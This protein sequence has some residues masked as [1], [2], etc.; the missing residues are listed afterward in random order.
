M[1]TFLLLASLAFAAPDVIN[2]PMQATRATV[3]ASATITNAGPVMVAT[4][5][6][7]RLGLV[8]Y[9]NSANTVYIKFG[10]PG[11]AGTDMT[12][13]IATFQSYQMP[14]PIF[15]GALFGIRN[16]GTGVVVATEL[17]LD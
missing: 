4:T 15:T 8:L 9:N 5:N 1:K 7:R 17:T 6:S 3:T 2:L 11:N 10:A 13:P 12:V 14:A 16:S